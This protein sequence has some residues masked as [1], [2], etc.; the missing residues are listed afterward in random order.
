MKHSIVLGL[1]LAMFACSPTGATWMGL[2]PNAAATHVGGSAANTTA[3][4]DGTYRGIFN[5]SL[6]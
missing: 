5:V 6:R 2:D 1:S 3:A 4:F